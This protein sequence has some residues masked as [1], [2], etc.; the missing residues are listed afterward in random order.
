MKISQ[1]GE[2]TYGLKWVSLWLPKHSQKFCWKWETSWGWETSFQ[3]MKITFFVEF[4]FRM[5]KS[6]ENSLCWKCQLQNEKKERTT[7]FYRWYKKIRVLKKVCL[8]IVC[9]DSRMPFNFEVYAQQK[10]RARKQESHRNVKLEKLSRKERKWRE[11][12]YL[13]CPKIQINLICKTNPYITFSAPTH[14]TVDTIQ[15]TMQRDT[16]ESD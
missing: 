2:N 4:G 15:A 9:S 6:S 12:Y 14:L 5:A 7:L 11:E 3:S 16:I 1:G 13:R 8:Q 10:K